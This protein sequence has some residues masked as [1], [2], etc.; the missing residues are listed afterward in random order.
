[1]AAH[2]AGRSGLWDP[3]WTADL[4]AMMREF[5]HLYADNSALCSPNR[6]RTLKHLLHDDMHHRVIH[7][8]DFPVPVTGVGAWIGGHLK[9]EDWRTHKQNQNPFEHDRL[10]KQAMG[11][12]PET[13]TRFDEVTGIS[14]AW[15][16]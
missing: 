1:M 12:K 14:K 5:P 15:K 10:L 9:W 8:S 3:D 4:A 13:F 6:W 2:G 7:G 16:R 11:F